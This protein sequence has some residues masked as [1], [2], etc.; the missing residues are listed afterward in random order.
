M[1]Q[2]KK[3]VMMELK[4]KKR[5]NIIIS[6]FIQSLSLLIDKYKII[7]N[8]QNNDKIIEGIVSILLYEN[9]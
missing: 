4:K 8:K 2:K 1:L 3:L 7:N 6:F 5:I 9:K